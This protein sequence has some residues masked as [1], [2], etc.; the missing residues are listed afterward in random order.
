MRILIL[1]FLT[2]CVHFSYAQQ[3]SIE[4][5]LKTQSGKSVPFASVMIKNTQ[6]K[7]IAFKSSDAE[8]RFGL[9]IPATQN[10]SGLSLE[11]NHLGFKKISEALKEGQNRYEIRMEEQSID[12][13]DV[14]V[15]S[16][17][18]LTSIGDTLSYDV[19]SFAKNEDRSIEDVI[20]RMP[21]M[22]VNEDGKIKFNGQDISNL[23]I[24]GDDLLDNKY[25]IGTKTIPYAMVQGVEVL[26][27]HQPLKVLKNKSIS[28]KIAVNLVIKEEAKLKLTGQAKLGAGLPNQYDGEVNTI[29]FNKKYK[30]LNVLKGNNIGND[31]SSDFTG[32]NF[33]SSLSGM[34]NSRPASLLSSGTAGNPNLPKNR[35]FLNNSGSLNANNLVNHKSG[36]QVKSNV[37]LLLDRNEMVYNSLSEYYSGE[38]TICYHERQ[39]LENHP[40]ISD[41]SFNA[42]VN[43]DTYY[44]NNALKFT[45]S[46]ETS[47]SALL[48]NE[49]DMSQKLQNRVRDFSNTLDYVPEL[50]NKNIISLNWYLNYYNQPQSLSIQPGI[51]ADIF[52]DGNAFQSLNQFAE[53]PT[54]FNKASL[55]YRLTRG[56]I[57]QNYRIGILNEFQ[58]L[59]SQLRVKQ[60]D[61]SENGYRA[62]ADNH[63]HWNRNQVFVD[64]SYEYKK[65][66]LEAVLSIPLTLQRIAYKDD[67]LALRENK[68]QWLVNP[69]LRLKQMT[70]MEDYLSFNYSYTNRTGNINSVFRGAVLSNYR[71]LR[72]NDAQLEEQNSHTLGLNYNYRRSITLFF[73]NAGLSYNR[74]SANTISSNRVDNDISQTISLSMVNNVNSFSANAGISK[75]IFSLGATADLKASW[76]STRFNQLFN[77]ELLPFNNLSFVLNPSIEARL[78]NRISMTYA[79]NASWMTS[80]QVR[81][82][83][84]SVFPD[85]HIQN[86]D[87]SLGFSYSP[88]RSAFIRLNGKHQYSRQPQSQ[89]VN[90]FFVDANARYKINRWRTDIELDLSNLANITTYDTYSLS[91]NRFVFNQYQ[92]RGRMAVLKMVFQL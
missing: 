69:A 88:F 50:K 20:K 16:R 14:Q 55:G 60:L 13:A 85:R 84:D 92:L 1:L 48:S 25:A 11:I 72:A 82:E 18:R 21:G 86:L 89:T 67:D 62:S 23:Y 91:A 46:K 4:G 39:D 24:D 76:S 15:K 36:L 28:D 53:T 45:Y 27:N 9:L 73:M 58:Q 47:H 79:G 41:L 37:K 33:A 65:G 80:R 49:V 71:S 5:T 75:Y 59:N 51:N 77:G 74:A 61:G 35:Y 66:G 68:N 19:G 83:A 22:E 81:E 29:L 8:G 30:T 44:F 90:Y 70:G 40:F 7:I 32:F 31:L 26:Q 34:G 52:N 17:P 87:Q 63:L 64:G 56:I 42:Q 78:W 10:L 38:D 2:V 43:K 57:K 6:N 12:L 3:Q 54:W